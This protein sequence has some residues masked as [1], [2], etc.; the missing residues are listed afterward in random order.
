M[1]RHWQWILVAALACSSTSSRDVAV[2]DAGMGG[3]GASFGPGG[4]SA[5][6]GGTGALGGVVFGPR[7][8]ASG[9]QGGGA[10]GDTGAAGIDPAR[11]VSLFR[12]I[13][14]YGLFAT[15]EPSYTP[16][17]GVLMWSFGTVF[18]RKLTSEEQAKLGSD[19]AARIT[20]H[21]HCDNYDRLGALFALRL[22]PGGVPQRTDPRWELARWVTPFSSQDRGDLATYVFP[23]ADLSAHAAGLADPSFDV[24]VGVAGG[25]NA[26]DGDACTGQSLDPD[27]RSVGF[28][29]SIDLVSSVPLSPLTNASPT[30]MRGATSAATASPIVLT[31]AHT[32]AEVTGRL[33]VIISGHGADAG[34]VEYRYTQDKVALNGLSLGDFVTKIDCA[35]YQRYSPEGNPALF[36]NNTTLNPRNWCPGALV[37]VH[38]FP[39]TL[40]AGDNALTIDMIPVDVP[41]GSSYSVSATFTA[42]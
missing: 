42:P 23:L 19:L 10:G 30:V 34:G 12:L 7:G 38:T 27:A 3:A 25:S 41:E 5:A 1:S 22:P 24:W 32:G 9:A 8:G 4:A 11:T 15:S 28:S 6:G 31:L 13:P 14:Q 16:P 36:H 29:Y 17:P 33:S 40:R 35:P 18:L 20:Y 26:Q 2:P 21:G 37:P 39:A